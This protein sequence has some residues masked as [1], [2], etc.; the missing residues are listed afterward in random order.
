MLP[1][2]APAWLFVVHLAVATS[3]CLGFVDGAC[4]TGVSPRVENLPVAAAHHCCIV[5]YVAA[6]LTM[7][8]LA[9]EVKDVA[10]LLLV[11]VRSRL[12]LR[13]T[14]HFRIFLR[15]LDN[16]EPAHLTGASHCPGHVISSPLCSTVTA[17]SLSVALGGPFIGA[18]ELRV[19]WRLCR[20]NALEPEGEVP[21]L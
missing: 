16:G 1:T 21:Q 4:T 10:G 19:P 18:V 15:P 5:E 14:L 12:A 17:P 3:G 7:A 8:G 13:L 20:G 11:L 9:I 2:A 6:A